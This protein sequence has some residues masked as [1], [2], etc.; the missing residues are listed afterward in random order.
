MGLPLGSTA[1]GSSLK[2]GRV[3]EAWVPSPKP[4]PRRSAPFTGL[5]TPLGAAGEWWWP[6]GAGQSLDLDSGM[7]MLLLALPLNSHPA[8]GKLP[9][10]LGSV[11]QEDFWASHSPSVSAPEIKSSVLEVP[12]MA[13]WNRILLV[14][15]RMQV[16]SLAL[17]SWLRIQH[18]CELW[19]RLQMWLRCGIAVAVAQAGS[20][21]SDSTPSLETSICCRYSA[22]KQKKEKKILN[23]YVYLLDSTA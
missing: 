1:K 22:K 19:C 5:W 20:C 23:S 13:Q 12:V 10:L 21:S 16:R 17:L 7:Q 4:R 3:S 9:F 6:K 14:S 8:W 11:N 18:C 2:V 15:I